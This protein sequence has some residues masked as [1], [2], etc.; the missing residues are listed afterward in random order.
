LQPISYLG[1]QSSLATPIDYDRFA[2]RFLRLRNELGN[3]VWEASENGVDYSRLIDMGPFPAERA[4]LR[5]IASPAAPTT[6]I[7]VSVGS[8][9]SDLSLR[10]ELTGLT[11]TF[12]AGDTLTAPNANWDVREAACEGINF[13]NSV[14]NPD[15]LVEFVYGPSPNACALGLRRTSDLSRERSR[16]SI[17]M[18]GYQDGFVFALEFPSRAT[19]HLRS[20]SSPQEIELVATTPSASMVLGRFSSIAQ[21]L[22]FERVAGG[23]NVVVGGT[24]LNVADAVFASELDR[25]GI[26]LAIRSDESL[27]QLLLEIGT[28][29]VDPR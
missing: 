23:V 16:V 25:V 7:D 8:V 21:T 29:V 28:L 2:H 20:R 12:L 18:L 22:S 27:N 4:Q 3:A 26:E 13:R 24:E 11:E 15:P 19:L 9:C 10:G 17:E 1:P 5:M 6:P 14:E